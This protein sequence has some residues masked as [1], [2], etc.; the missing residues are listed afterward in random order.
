MMAPTVLWTCSR[1]AQEGRNESL[2]FPPSGWQTATLTWRWDL[3]RE[4]RT[5]LVFCPDCVQWAGNPHTALSGL[6]V[7]DWLRTR[8]PGEAGAVAEEADA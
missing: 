8:P 2:E 4:R 3:G 5:V 6:L 7:E 1:C